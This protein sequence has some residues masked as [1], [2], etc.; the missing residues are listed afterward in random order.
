MRMLF[1]PRKMTLFFMAAFGLGGAFLGIP[2]LITGIVL[3]YFAGGVYSQLRNDKAVLAYF[4]NPGPSAFYEGEPG[5]AAFCALGAYLMSRASPKI[6]ENE[7]AAVRIAGGAVSVF[8]EG[9]KIGPLAESFCRLAYRKLSALNPDLLSESLAARRR[10][11]GDL[12]L[13]GLE[14]GSMASGRE[15]LQE[16]LY[17]RQ[18][19]E[20]GFEPLPEEA[21]GEDP[22]LVLDIPRGTPYEEVKSAFRKLALACHPDNRSGVDEAEKQRLEEQFIRVRDAYRTITREFSVV[23]PRR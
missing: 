11:K 22:W 14:L 1:T 5:L 6:L 20:P 19:L 8:P 23:R 13:I 12:A 16:A 17:I 15:A 3:G 7:T 10:G 18:F 4:E 21:P 2:A 9:K